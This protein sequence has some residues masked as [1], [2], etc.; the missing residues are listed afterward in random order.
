M[1]VGNHD[2]E[3]LVI[4]QSYGVLPTGRTADPVLQIDKKYL[5]IASQCIFVFND[6]NLLS[7]QKLPRNP[8]ILYPD[9]P[10]PEGL[11]LLSRLMPDCCMPRAN[12]ARSLSP[13]GGATLHYGFEW[14]PT[15]GCILPR[16]RR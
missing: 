5:E 1:N 15:H 12:L 11:L 9:N 16:L 14:I 6:Q 3:L 8:L 13:A 7:H 10:N 2:I 4:E